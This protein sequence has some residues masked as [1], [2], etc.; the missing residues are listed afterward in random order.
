MV[1]ST[2]PDEETN[3]HNARAHPRSH[4][5]VI[6]RAG[7]Q[8]RIKELHW[9][10]LLPVR[11]KLSRTKTRGKRKGTCPLSVATCPPRLFLQGLLSLAWLLITDYSTGS[12]R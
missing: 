8:V 12:V 3:A 5:E 9:A 7:V 2:A 6:C 10:V 11:E 1:T 4:K